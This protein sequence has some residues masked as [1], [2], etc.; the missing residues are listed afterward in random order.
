M[1]YT[2]LKTTILNNHII[3]ICMTNSIMCEL[4]L[5][6]SCNGFSCEAFHLFFLWPTADFCETMRAIFVVFVV[7]I[8]DAAPTYWLWLPII[9]LMLDH[10]QAQLQM[11]T[12]IYC[13]G[14]ITDYCLYLFRSILFR[15]WKLCRF[16]ATLKLDF[17]IRISK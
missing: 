15:D 17:K 8:D 14:L 5:K 6:F 2:K 16:S 13:L 3:V 12:F 9:T 4:I 1:P 11:R 10:R 7:A